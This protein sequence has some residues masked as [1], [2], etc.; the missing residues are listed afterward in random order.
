VNYSSDIDLM[1]VYSGSSETGARSF[2][3]CRQPDD[4]NAVH[5]HSRRHVLPVDLR[6]RP[7]G[8]L[9]ELCQPLEPPG[10]TMA[11]GSRLGT[12]DA[13][14]GAR[15]RGE[16]G[17]GGI[18]LFVSADLPDVLPTSARLKLFPNAGAHP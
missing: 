15:R 16:A 5:L 14:Q 12:P 4:G 10:S 11:N 9:G 13:D 2:Q 7:D 17:L 18:T 1:F 6:L 8:S 3:N